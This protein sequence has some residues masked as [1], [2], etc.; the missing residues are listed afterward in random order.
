MV[1]NF[2]PKIIEKSIYDIDFDL[3]YQNGKKFI[4]SDLDN[5]LI[6]Y[7]MEKADEE[8]QAFIKKLEDKG[9][10]LIIVS[11]NNKKRVERFSK[12][13]NLKCFHSALKPLNHGLGKALKHIKKTYLPDEK[14]EDIKKYVVTIGDQLMTDVLGSNLFELD[15]ILVKPLKKKSEKWYTKLNR[16]HEKFVIKRIKKKYYNVY[17]EI[18]T[19]HED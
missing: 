1:K 15:S 8:L 16:M 14:I 19:K 3:L 5:T 17:E 18:I 11:N 7:D 9:Y 10:T 4:L 13:L 6:P 12:D 2:I